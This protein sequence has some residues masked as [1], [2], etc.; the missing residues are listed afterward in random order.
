MAGPTGDKLLDEAIAGTEKEIFGG[1]FGE[2]GNVAHDDAPDTSLE[3]MED[4][5]TSDATATGDDDGAASED[6]AGD[7]DGDAGGKDDTGAKGADD[8]AKGKP[9]AEESRDKATGQFKPKGEEGTE[10]PRKGN[11]GIALRDER[12]RNETLR[13]ELEK[14]RSERQAERDRLSKLEGQLDAMLKGQAAQ[15]K[16]ET[17]SEA[18]A[19][20]EPDMFVDYDG[21][22]AWNRR[23]NDQIAASLRQSFDNRLIDMSFGQAH[24]AHGKTFEAAYG[25]VTSLNPQN[26]AHVAIVNRIRSAPNPGAALM[27]WHK[28]QQTLERVGDDPDA[29]IKGEVARL[30][31]DPEVRKQVLADMRAEAGG[32]RGGEQQQRGP[33]RNVI[34]NPRSLNSEGGRAERTNDNDNLDD[35]EAAVFAA[36]WK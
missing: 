22:K 10:K 32:D 9:D 6:E 20:A 13:T 26:S 34:R 36:A 21:W 12:A 16:T 5:V 31:K 8:D 23:Q 27:K 3:E 2:D 7:E 29:F 17:K 28:Q 35:S 30:L 19:D 25:A 14:E 11:P 1:A 18:T 4:D 24:E 33:I 15:P